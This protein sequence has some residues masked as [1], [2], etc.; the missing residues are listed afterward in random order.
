MLHSYGIKQTA[1]AA[2]H[3]MKKHLVVCQHKAKQYTCDNMVPWR[4]CIVYLTHILP[5]FSEMTSG[6][7]ASSH[8][9]DANAAQVLL[10]PHCGAGFQTGATMMA[11]PRVDRSTVSGEF[12]WVP[13]VMLPSNIKDE[14]SLPALRVYDWQIQSL[15]VC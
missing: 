11:S 7:F 14:L 8:L 3:K 9:P 12:L 10:T 13:P 15:P 4:C 1:A 5:A 6:L 2:H